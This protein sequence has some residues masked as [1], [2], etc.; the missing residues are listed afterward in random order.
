MRWLM[1]C[2]LGYFCLLLVFLGTL[3]TSLHGADHVALEKHVFEIKSG[4][5]T[6]TLPQV[7]HQGSVD[8]MFAVGI[9][10]GV[11]TNPVDGTY[12]PLEALEV[13]LANTPL[14]IVEDRETGAFAVTRVSEEVKSM[15]EPDPTTTQ[16]DTEPRTTPEMTNKKGIFNSLLSGVA[17][18]LTFSG[19]A[20][21][22]QEADEEIVTLQAYEIYGA[23]QA[24]SV[25]RQKQSDIIGSYLSSD[26]LSEL[27]DDDLGEALSRLAGVN[28]VGGQGNAEG[29]VTIRGADGQ[30]NTIRINGASQANA[31]LGSRN[32]DVTQIPSE[33]V[34]GVEIIKS[35]TAEHPA[36]SIGGSV[37]VETANAFDLG[38]RT[39]RYKF[40]VRNRDQGDENGWGVNFVH[41]DI[42]DAFGGENNLGILFNVNYVDEDL[43]EWS[44]Q[45]RFLDQTNRTP[46][47]SD[48]NRDSFLEQTVLAVNPNASNPIWDRFD[49]NEVRTTRDEFT[50]NASID[51]LLSDTTSLYFRPWYQ[52]ERDV[53]DSFAFRVDRLERAFRGNYWFLDDSG[54]PLGEWIEDDDDPVLG[55][56]GDTFVQA[57]DGS[58]NI[59]VTPDFEAN[60]DGRVDRIITGSN[61]DSETYTF[62]FGGETQLDRGLIEYRVL[63]STDE[64]DNFR[65]QW[66]F[67]EDFRK[68]NAGDPLRARWYGATPL[69]SFS[70]FEV[71][72]GRGHV[73][74]NGGVNVFSDANRSFTNTSPRFLYENVTEDVLLASFDVEQEVSDFLVLKAGARFRSAKRDNQTTEL[75]INPVEGNNKVYPAGQF[76]DPADG[77]F[78][79]W[80]G[81]Y[82]DIAGPFV[83]ADPAYDFFFSDYQSSPDNWEWNR[84]DLRDAADTAELQ[85]DIT[86]AYMQGTFRW[87]NFTLVTGLRVETTQLDTTWKPSNFI[88]D[89]SN[90]PNLN[91]DQQGILN[92]IL[93]EG[94]QD[95]GF[96]GPDGTFSFGDIVNDIRRTNSYD[97]AL[98]S[99]VLSYRAGDSGHVFRFAWTNTLTR[100]DYRELIPFDLGEANRQL[101]A[102]GVLNLTNRDDEFDLGNPNLLEQTSENFDLAW[103]YYFGP[104]QRNMVSVTAFKKD[105]EDFLLEY[106]F[107]REIEVL[108]DPEDPSL[109]TEFVTSDTRFWSNASER[110]IE[111]VE[112]TGYF[113]F[114]DMF[115]NIDLLHGLSFVP[116]YAYITGDQNDPIFDEDRLADGEFDILGYQFTDSL[117]NQAKEI[118][119][120]QLFYEQQR[121][122]V[123]LSYNWISS[124]QRTPSTAAI[125]A[126]TFDREQENL[127]L[128]I[129]Y[130]LFADKDIRVFFEGDNLSDTPNDERYI[131]PNAGLFTTSYQTIGRRYVLGVRG[132]F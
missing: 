45:N 86:A 6:S 109:G 114:E 4:E 27:P 121:F 75:F 58:G 91:S 77:N 37:N 10:K 39:S 88:I 42:L 60:W 28:V 29:S 36:D 102:A 119:N 96:V 106:T 14:T 126:I 33:M 7:A 47:G 89:G 103:E 1:P 49:P 87:D 84:S 82:S 63:F 122:N 12:T 78:T 101:Q 11:H 116:N 48:P 80:D 43:V 129:Q 74:S 61:I 104:Q 64:G 110:S 93:Q 22:A 41:S 120:L 131:G 50:F 31:R 65:R 35:I 40:E 46:N 72:E 17:A 70:V 81:T 97:N 62:D 24:A 107:Q 16:L 83:R 18:V 69:P 32:F 94:V 125:S 115:P 8:V 9:A 44:T 15:P 54:N 66:R 30:Y 90:I 52:K 124:L 57:T 56:E 23:A 3:L 99:A 38:R 117:T 5:A 21:N 123:R 20:A 73:P 34:S 105:L 127:D 130:R 51:L 111:G 98:P 2:G 67:Q 19:N 118:Y 113:N 132:S 26:A 85:E 100:P 13:M 76:A 25:E 55:S 92:E 68:T 128:S 59:I 71:T 112:F 79:L 108:V 95:L 53:R